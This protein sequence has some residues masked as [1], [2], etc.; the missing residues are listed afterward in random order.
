MK[1]VLV[2]PA[3]PFRGGIAQY[4]QVLCLRLN[5]AGHNAV[6][7]SFKRQF[8]RLL[9]PGKTQMDPSQERL[10]VTTYPVFAPLNPFSW[11]QSYRRIKG[12]NPDVVLFN[13]F[14][15]FFGPGFWILGRLCKRRAR[16]VFLLHNVIP[17]EAYP[18]SRFLTRLAL[19]TGKY[20]IAH[21]RSVEQDLYQWLPEI[22]KEYV[23]VSP[24]PIYDCYEPFQGTT[25]Q[26]REALGI[27][28]SK[29]LLFFGL[30]REY[31]GLQLHVKAMPGLLRR[32]GK[33]VHLMVVGEFY[34]DRKPYDDL[35]ARL[36]IGEQVTIHDA[37]VPNEEVGRYFAAADVAVL[38]YK[39]ATQSG[40]IQMAY[41]LECPVITTDVGGLGEVVESGKSGFVVPP[42]T[43]DA[44]VEAVEKFYA[45][46]GRP[47]FREGVLRQRSKY[48]WDG[49]IK[50]IE[51]LV[52]K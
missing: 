25:A 17:H 31:K 7:V 36:G 4:G 12:E 47:A 5:Q 48:S 50:T 3:Y 37:Y 14:N 22:H 32:A 30:V 26:A 23:A 15:P 33:E 21:G 45:D 39:S 34:E 10:P 42:E 11:W 49:M 24:H 8:P 1:I 52:Q 40:I 6:M 9:F 27:N 44:I 13:W 51:N 46:G 29:V 18:G 19:R 35:I 16:I 38:P 2:G 28:A 41:H 43:P 20:F